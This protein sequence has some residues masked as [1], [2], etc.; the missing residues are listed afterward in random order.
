MLNLPSSGLGLEAA[1]Q[2]ATAKPRRLILAVRNLSKGNAAAEEIARTTSYQC[3]V[4]ELDQASFASVKAFGEKANK[5][6]DR[7]DI[8]LA[9]AGITTDR[10]ER[11]GDGYEA[12]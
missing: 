2:L 11:T 5:E 7:L 3:E 9:N 8:C 1:R 10:F 6:L 4:W 12:A